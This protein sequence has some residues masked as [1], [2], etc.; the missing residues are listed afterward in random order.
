VGSPL[1]ANFRERVQSLSPYSFT[2]AP[3]TLHRGVFG[4]IGPWCFYNRTQVELWQGP[5]CVER[6]KKKTLNMSALFSYR[7]AT[8]AKAAKQ[9]EADHQ[10]RPHVLSVHRSSVA[11]SSPPLLPSPTVEVFWRR[12]RNGALSSLFAQLSLERLNLG[13][14]IVHVGDG[15]CR[16]PCATG[17]WPKQAVIRHYAQ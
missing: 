14:L 9:K 15:S 16:A 3:Y 7:L 13:T 17:L 11:F 10:R 6:L 5:L 8:F 1:V 12:R 2:V 4:I